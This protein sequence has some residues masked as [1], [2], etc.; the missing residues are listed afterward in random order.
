MPWRKE[1]CIKDKHDSYVEAFE[2]NV[3]V[4]KQT[5]LKYERFSEEVREAE[6]LIDATDNDENDNIAPTTEQEERDNE[7]LGLTD[8]A[9]YGFFR[10]PKGF[11]P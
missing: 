11:S 3:A 9:E 7:L 2:A 4:I 1:E 8:S 6:E 5:M 10:P